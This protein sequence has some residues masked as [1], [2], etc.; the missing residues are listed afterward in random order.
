MMVCDSHGRILTMVG[1]RPSRE[2]FCFLV[3]FSSTTWSKGPLTDYCC[4]FSVE[5]VKNGGPNRAVQSLG[6]QR[7]S[8][9]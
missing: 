2:S 6:C 5:V 1:H 3:A 7:V 8:L 4:I 9:T